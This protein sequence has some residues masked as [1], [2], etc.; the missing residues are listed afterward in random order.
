[1]RY[2]MQMTIQKRLWAYFCLLMMSFCFG[3]MIPIAKAAMEGGVPQ[4]TLTGM[5]MA[6]TAVFFWVFALGKPKIDVPVR[7]IWLMGL[8]GFFCIFLDQGLFIVGLSYTSPIDAGIITTMIPVFSLVLAVLFK[9]MKPSMVRILGIAIGLAGAVTMVLSTGTESGVRSS[10]FGDAI[11]IVAILCFCIYLV[12]FTELISRY[13]VYVLMKWMFLF[14]ALLMMPFSLWF[15]TAD[16][17]ASV[18]VIS[19]LEALYVLFG[20][21][22]FAFLF[23]LEGQKYCTPDVVGVFSYIQPV[24]ASVLAIMLGLGEFTL[25]KAVGTVL[26][27]VSVL[28]VTRTKR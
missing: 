3:S 18:P 16:V 9:A 6:G 28:I 1:M 21:T 12:F 4:C 26:I 2:G 13:P 17:I 10:V 23:M 14:S 11:V 20:G 27:F 19:W 15:T 25:A 7:D 5:R 24:V 8:A 22:V